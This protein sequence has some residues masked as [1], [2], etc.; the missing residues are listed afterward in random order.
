[1]LQLSLSLPV[2]ASGKERKGG[3]NAKKSDKNTGV[4]EH[5]YDPTVNIVCPSDHYEL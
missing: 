4:D 1:M 2:A 5:F 3:N